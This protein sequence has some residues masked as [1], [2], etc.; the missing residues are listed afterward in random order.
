MV[1]KNIKTSQES[2][3][4]ETTFDVDGHIETTAGHILS[5][6][7]LLVLLFS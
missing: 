1:A 3:D 2:G 4:F 5:D 6:H 7:I